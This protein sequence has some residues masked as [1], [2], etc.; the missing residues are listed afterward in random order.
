MRSLRVLLVLAALAVFGV[1]VIHA[2]DEPVPLFTDGRVNNTQIDAPVGIYCV[3]DRSGDGAVFQRIEV[4]GLNGEKLL[5]ASAAE[6]AA[7]TSGTTLDTAWSYTLTK[8]T[9][10]GFNVSAP[11]GYSY[12]WQ[13]GDLG[14]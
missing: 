7:A 5:D 14:C 9:S 10:S 8:L 13:R 1:G 6:I 4:W 12:T 11:N 2:D 3:F